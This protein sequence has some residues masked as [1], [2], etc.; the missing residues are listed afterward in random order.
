MRQIEPGC[1]IFEFFLCLR[2][3]DRYV[4][5][6]YG[7]LVKWR[8]CQRLKGRRRTIRFGRRI[9][10]KPGM[11]LNCWLYKRYPIDHEVIE[12]KRSQPKS[13]IDAFGLHLAQRRNVLDSRHT[14]ISQLHLQTRE[15]AQP[16]RAT[17]RKCRTGPVGQMFSKGNPD[18]PFA[19]QKWSGD[20][21]GNSD[22]CGEQRSKETEPETH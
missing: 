10:L 7:D 16:H 11:G 2:S 6:L 19:Q 15:I 17:D 9:F 5:I 14:D 13:D 12:E 8:A 20:E 22:H 4:A 21:I 3:G 18:C 1:D